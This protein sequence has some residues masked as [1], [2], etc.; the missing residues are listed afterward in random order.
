MITN[1]PLG[2]ESW[3]F[4]VSGSVQ[5]TSYA[6]TQ[7]D[8][9]KAWTASGAYTLTSATR[10]SDGVIT[11]ATIA[12]PDGSSGTFTTVTKNAT[13]LTVDSYTATHSVSGKTATQ[14][15]V[16]RDDSGNVTSQLAITIS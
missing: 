12:W 13:F 9:L 2:A 6:T 5:R 11:I 3:D 1:G 10:D 4:S 14:P 15:S 16:T 8:Q 7:N